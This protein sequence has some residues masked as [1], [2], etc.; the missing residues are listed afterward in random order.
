MQKYTLKNDNGNIILQYKMRSDQREILEEVKLWEQYE[1]EWQDR[2]LSEIK[3]ER[4][5][6][7]RK[8]RTPQRTTQN[9]SNA[10]I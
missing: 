10:R 2:M 6:A 9:D 3:R 4:K 7:Q 8:R 1:E 5:R